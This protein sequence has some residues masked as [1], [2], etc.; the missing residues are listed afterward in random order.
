MRK[1][2]RAEAEA[3]RHGNEN[4]KKTSPGGN[5]T[6]RQNG[7]VCRANETHC[8]TFYKGIWIEPIDA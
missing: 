1:R 4:R 5:E 2:D 7:R 8:L 3:G 6:I